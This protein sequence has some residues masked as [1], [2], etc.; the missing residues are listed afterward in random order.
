MLDFNKIR[1]TIVHIEMAGVDVTGHLL[2]DLIE[3]EHVDDTQHNLDEVVIRL[4]DP[5]H[6]YLTAW[7]IERGAQVKCAIS[8]VSWDMPGQIKKLECGT[9]YVLDVD[10]D[11]P[12]G[13]VTIFATSLR[14]DS[15]FRDSKVSTAYENTTLKDIAAQVAQKHGLTLDYQAPDNPQIKRLD[16]DQE[17]DAEFL[18]R[19]CES[20]GLQMKNQD[21]KLIIFDE[22]DHESRASVFTVSRLTTPILKWRLRENGQGKFAKIKCKYFNP[23]TGVVNSQEWGP[24]SP[25][26]GSGDKTQE[27]VDRPDEE[28][29][30]DES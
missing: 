13:T 11:E 1:Q 15:N 12:P 19:K 27:D 7:T 6:K 23:N 5:Q 4:A 29:D 8:M 30:D 3:F 16:Q 10:Y 25:P 9:F 26:E 17:S 22:K 18:K 20:Q 24:V 21:G 28:P 2:P 14:M